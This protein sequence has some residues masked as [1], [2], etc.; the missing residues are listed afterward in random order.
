M[1]I[2][3][4]VLSVNSKRVE[5]NSRRVGVKSTPVG[6]EFC[7]TNVPLYPC[8]TFQLTLQSEIIFYREIARWETVIEIDYVLDV[9]ITSCKIKCGI[10]K[11]CIFG[12]YSNCLVFLIHMKFSQFIDLRQLSTMQFHRFGHTFLQGISQCISYLKQFISWNSFL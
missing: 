4:L 1:K 10:K 3:N 11:T 5:V 6:V 2:E 9:V 8:P 12:F 7:R